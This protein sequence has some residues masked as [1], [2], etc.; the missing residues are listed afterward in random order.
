M[1]NGVF[2]SE[3]TLKEFWWLECLGGSVSE[4]PARTGEAEQPSYL[5]G[6]QRVAGLS[7]SLLP[8]GEGTEGE[9]RIPKGSC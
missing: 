1:E 5:E 2:A 3:S 4:I 8:L 7:I 6:S 9:R